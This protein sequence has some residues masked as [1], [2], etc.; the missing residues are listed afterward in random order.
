MKNEWKQLWFL[1]IYLLTSK[2][3]DNNNKKS[4]VKQDTHDMH[5]QLQLKI[6]KKIRKS[7]INSQLRILNGCL[8]FFSLGFFY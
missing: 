4:T 5:T 1:F 8:L 2:V 3:M 6:V 7:V